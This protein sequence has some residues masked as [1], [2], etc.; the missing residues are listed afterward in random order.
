MTESEDVLFDRNIRNEIKQIVSKT[1][2][3][4]A[5]YSK[6]KLLEIFHE[7]W[8]IF[9]KA[10]AA[11]RQMASYKQ[12]IKKSDQ[13]V[14]NYLKAIKEHNDSVSKYKDRLP[15]LQEIVDNL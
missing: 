1:I 12:M 2:E 11:K 3:H 13:I 9:N 4:D 10:C 8:S 7:Q 15:K 5:T 6:K 14:T